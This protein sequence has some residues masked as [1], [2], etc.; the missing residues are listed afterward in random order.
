MAGTQVPG[1]G[2]V[3][4]VLPPD[5]I[6]RVES[7]GDGTAISLHVYGTDIG[8]RPRRAFDPERRSVKTFISGYTAPDQA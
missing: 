6:H 5:D 3:T 7:A 1:P 8:M 4:I 2:E